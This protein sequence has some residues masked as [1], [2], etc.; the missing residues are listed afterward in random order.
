MPYKQAFRVHTFR[1]QWIPIFP[2]PTKFVFTTDIPM[3]F[4]CPK[5]TFLKMNACLWVSKGSVKVKNLYFWSLFQPSFH[6]AAPLAY[7]AI[8]LHRVHSVLERSCLS[9]LMSPVAASIA[10]EN[11][12]FPLLCLSKER[13]SCLFVHYAFW[14]PVS[15]K[16]G[17]TP[18]SNRSSSTSHPVSQSPATIT[19]LN[20]LSS[21]WSSR[22]FMVI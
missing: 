21:A 7:R 18:R 15:H 5:I 10:H 3:T 22:G 6:I 2:F 17:T 9:A 16:A 19:H 12:L 8:L 13:K 11:C 20:L 4:S 14:H 1:N